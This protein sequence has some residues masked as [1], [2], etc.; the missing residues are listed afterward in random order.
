MLEDTAEIKTLRQ[1]A[2]DN[3]RTIRLLERSLGQG[4]VE[5][6]EHASVGSQTDSRHADFRLESRHSVPLKMRDLVVKLA[7]SRLVS[8]RQAFPAVRD[9]QVAMQ[10]EDATSAAQ[11][12]DG[13][14]TAVRCIKEVSSFASGGQNDRSV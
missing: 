13:H 12:S 7:V 5:D 6:E 9:A 10:L 14:D 11:A 4:R 2:K 8:F 1:Q 3:S